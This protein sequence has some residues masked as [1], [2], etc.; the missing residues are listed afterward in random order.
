M[1]NK[2]LTLIEYTPDLDPQPGQPEEVRAPLILECRRDRATPDD[3]APLANRLASTGTT[4]ALW[5]ETP[6]FW[7]K[8]LARALTV[9]FTFGVCV[10]IASFLIV[11]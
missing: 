9:G 10:T 1:R 4:R 2:P 8:K 5:A 3:L 6:H 7:Q 11:N